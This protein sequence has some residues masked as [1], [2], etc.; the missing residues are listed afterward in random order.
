MQYE[1]SPSHITLRE[2]GKLIARVT[3]HAEDGVTYIDKTFVEEEY[4][5]R[6]IADRLVQEAAEYIRKSGNKVKPICSYAVK[7]F[8]THKSYHDLLA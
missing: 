7:W 8:E 4:R 2:N 5:G 6:Q 1:Y 3:M